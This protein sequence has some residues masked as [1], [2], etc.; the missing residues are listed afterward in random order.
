MPSRTPFQQLRTSLRA[1]NRVPKKT[2]G[3][4]AEFLRCLACCSAFWGPSA[5]GP[6]SCQVHKGASPSVEE[7]L[8]GIFCR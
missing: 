7:A 3:P 1:R 2:W 4:N 6:R 8:L 5:T